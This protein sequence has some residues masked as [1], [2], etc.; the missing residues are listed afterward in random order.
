MTTEQELT[1]E[2]F[3]ELL[4]DEDVGSVSEIPYLDEMISADAQEDGTICVSALAHD[5]NGDLQE[6]YAE[7]FSDA[8]NAFDAYNWLVW[9]YSG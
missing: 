9:G 7:F 6:L 1:F 8:R 2:L 3:V 4:N 5:E